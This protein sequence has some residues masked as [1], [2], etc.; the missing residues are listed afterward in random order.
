M[1]SSVEIGKVSTKINFAS[2][3]DISLNYYNASGKEIKYLT[4][5]FVPYNAV[6]DEVCCTISNE[7]EKA[8]QITGPIKAF[9]IAIGEYDAKYNHFYPE[10]KLPSAKWDALWY[11]NTITRVEVTQID[12]TY[13]DD[14]E[15]T[16]TEEDIVHMDDENSAWTRAKEAAK[17]EFDKLVEKYKE[18]EKIEK[19][20]RAEEDKKQRE[21]DER[22]NKKKR[23]KGII[24]AAIVVV[25]LIVYTIITNK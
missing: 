18:E 8:G 21:E 3:V 23:K 12:I 19:E 5:T 11:N 17:E 4:F 13:M 9:N 16:I 22:I 6:N 10:G 24:I 1:S 15:E 25:I 14:S 7:S 2:G 20:K